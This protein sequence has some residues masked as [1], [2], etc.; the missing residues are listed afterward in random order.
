MVFSGVDST[1]RKRVAY[2][3]HY[4]RLGL[5]FCHLFTMKSH[6]EEIP[7]SVNRLLDA[8]GRPPAPEERGRGTGGTLGI[9]EVGY[10]GTVGLKHFRHP[11]GFGMTDAENAV[12]VKQLSD[13]VKFALR[14]M[15]VDSKELEASITILVAR[16]S[17]RLEYVSSG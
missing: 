17:L 10:L 3:A 8:A 9:F 2:L 12:I 6:A 13:A 7:R 5:I 11:L 15:E 4:S 1:D 16:L 14:E